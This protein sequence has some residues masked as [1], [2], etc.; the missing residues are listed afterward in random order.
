MLIKQKNQ[1]PH[2]AQGLCQAHNENKH[3]SIFISSSRRGKTSRIECFKQAIKSFG[4]LS[5][6]EDIGRLTHLKERTDCH[7]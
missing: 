6:I 1:K 4:T 3:G 5:G 2:K 7:D